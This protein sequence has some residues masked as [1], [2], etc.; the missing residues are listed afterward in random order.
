MVSHGGFD[1]YFPDDEW[2][3]AWSVGHLDVF[4][5]EVSIHVFCPLNGLLPISSLDYL[6]FGC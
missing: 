3:G 1:L 2:C 4:L 5:G 6:F